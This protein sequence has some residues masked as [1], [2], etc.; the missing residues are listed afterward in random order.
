[1]HDHVI[2][3]PVQRALTLPRSPRNELSTHLD[4]STFL[5][6]LYASNADK[7]LEDAHG[8]SVFAPT[9]DAFNRLGLLAKHLLHPDSQED[10]QHV[11][12]YHVVRGVFYNQLMK[13]GEYRRDTLLPTDDTLD[14]NKTKQGLFVRGHGATDGNDRFVLGRVINNSDTLMSNGALHT[15]DR[16]Q[17]PASLHVNNRQLMSVE[18]THNL[19]LQLIQENMKEMAKKVLNDLDPKAPYTILAP[20]DNAF[21]RFTAD[22]ADLMDD[23]ERL[24]E[25]IKLHIIPGKLPRLSLEDDDLPFVGEEFPTLLDSRH[26][27]I[28]RG[29][30]GGYSVRVKDSSRFSQK[31]VDA[32][33]G[34]MGRNTAGGGVIMIDR[35][36]VPKEKIKPMHFSWWTIFL[37]ALGG[38]VIL[39]NAL[40]LGFMCWRWYKGY[41]NGGYIRLTGEN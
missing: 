14:L 36:L 12:L 15:I 29:M 22:L 7:A 38:V 18:G 30:H 19:F 6:S 3:Y 34:Q 27:V 39:I 2:I 37:M 32:E 13:E 24:K 20:S 26:I 5:A 35:V 1:M 33:I 25:L 8:V 31:Q 17:L 41:T 4:L 9:N 40:I 16:V 21:N 23:K 28:E 10:L 11:V